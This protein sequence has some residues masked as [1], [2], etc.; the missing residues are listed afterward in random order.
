MSKQ[1]VEST[2]WIE[3]QLWVAQ[4]PSL[5]R[6]FLREVNAFALWRGSLEAKSKG[7]EDFGDAGDSGFLLWGP[8]DKGQGQRRWRINL[9]SSWGLGAVTGED[10]GLGADSEG[11]QSHR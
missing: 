5:K 10:R 1:L 9:A 6:S 2:V 3:I 7:G 8:G 11:Q 4:N